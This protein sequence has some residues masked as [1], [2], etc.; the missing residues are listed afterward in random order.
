MPSAS[1]PGLEIAIPFGITAGE[2]TCTLVPSSIVVLPLYVF[3]PFMQ[4]VA[5][6]LIV[7]P[8]VDSPSG[9]MKLSM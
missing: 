7:M 3:T 9:M 6:P 1:V 4:R 8:P 5:P 2:D